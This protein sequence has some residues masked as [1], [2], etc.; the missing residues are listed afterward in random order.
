MNL[1]EYVR[2]LSVIFWALLAGQVLFTAMIFLIVQSYGALMDSLVDMINIFQGIV[3]LFVIGSW[4][5]RRMVSKVRLQEI[6]KEEN[7]KKKIIS[8]R[9]NLILK[10]ALMEAPVFVILIFYLM[11]ADTLLLI[12]SILLI[13]VF[14]MNKPDRGKIVNE[15]RIYDLDRVKA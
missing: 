15:L 12:L 13:V 3:I 1:E 7:L 2:N 14:F 8:Y 11:T 10:Y 4:I 9:A 6:L 5:A